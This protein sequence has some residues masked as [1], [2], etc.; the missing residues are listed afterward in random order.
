M[1]YDGDQQKD[2]TDP[3]E[4]FR[5][6]FDAVETERIT[7]QFEL[8]EALLAPLIRMTP[9]TWEQVKSASMKRLRRG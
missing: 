3:V 1:F 6:Q 5:E 7:Y 4:S 9:L 8:P 2:E